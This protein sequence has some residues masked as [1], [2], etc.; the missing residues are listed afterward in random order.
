MFGW[1][2]NKSVDSRTSTS[3]FS[4][5]RPSE[6]PSGSNAVL[7]GTVFTFWENPV[8]QLKNSMH[9]INEFQYHDKIILKW[10]QAF[11]Q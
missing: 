6:E 11:F 3:N 8:A 2:L 5:I 1:V 4:L 10:L 9:V 7:S